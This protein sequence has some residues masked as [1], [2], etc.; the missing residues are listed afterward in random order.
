MIS[1]FHMS[2]FAFLSKSAA[3]PS[4]DG[5]DGAEEFGFCVAVVVKAL[6]SDTLSVDRE[7]VEDAGTDEDG[8]SD[9]QS[10]S[11]LSMISSTVVLSIAKSLITPC[12]IK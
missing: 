11:I 10:R 12:L 6:T 1:L 3:V 9:W 2:Y 5:D 7:D 4:T 8:E